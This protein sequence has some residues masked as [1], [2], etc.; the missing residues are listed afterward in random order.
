[1]SSS[2]CAIRLKVALARNV[3]DGQ[4][5]NT[6]PCLITS[7]YTYGSKLPASATGNQE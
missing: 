7:L 2:A 1:V 5:I 4:K 6:V 3:T